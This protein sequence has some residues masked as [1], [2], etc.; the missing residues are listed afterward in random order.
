MF[1]WFIELLQENQLLAAGVG[2]TI[3]G[4][5]TYQV[6]SIPSVIERHA[7]YQFTTTLDVTDREDTFVALKYWL[8]EQSKKRKLR[9]VSLTTHTDEKSEDEVEWYGYA[10]GRH[11]FWFKKR[12]VILNLT[13]RHKDDGVRSGGYTEQ[14]SL[15][16]IGRNS[17]IWVQLLETAKSCMEGATKFDCIPIM[18]KGYGGWS[19]NSKVSLRSRETVIL[20]DSANALVE[21]V[22]EFM[23][24]EDWYKERGIPYKR[25]YLLYGPPG[26]GKTSFVKVLASHF[27]KPIGIV[28]LA[29]I[30]SDTD[31]LESFS[32]SVPP[33][34][35]IEDIDHVVDPDEDKLKVSLSGLLNVFGGITSP[36]GTIIIMTTNNPERIPAKL[37]R[38]GRVD[39]QIEF[40]NT[41]REQ[42]RK[43]FDLFYKDA[44]LADRFAERIEDGQHSAALLQSHF[45]RYKSDPELA[46]S[47]PITVN[48]DND[49]DVV[50]NE[51]TVHQTPTPI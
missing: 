28:D 45:L 36:E 30:S 14:I 23:D 5:I 4:A 40:K 39:V 21:D 38:P 46:I 17:D 8:S 32:G 7:I 29:S 42:A 27:K 41:S 47:R 26:N 16:T 44:L 37:I 43:M 6:R 13:R 31:L 1:Q 33:I 2:T 22:Q 50:E 20:P 15:S 34:L 19:V 9:H 10:P 51:K 24:S 49:T 35:L 25:G 11:L 3:V 18:M 48:L 12:P